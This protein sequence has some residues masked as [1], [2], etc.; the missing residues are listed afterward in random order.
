MKV[1]KLVDN[2]WCVG[3][4]RA[5]KAGATLADAILAKVHGERGITLI[6]FGLAARVVYTCLMS[7][8]ERR[9]FTLVDS[10]VL[11]G[12]PVSSEGNVWV[13]MKSVTAGRLVN[14]YS[15]NDSLLGFMYRTGSHQFGVAGLQPVEGAKGIENVDVSDL[16]TD[17]SRYQHLMG[18][19]LKRI[20]WDD[21]SSA[22]LA[23][24]EHSL[25]ILDGR[26]MVN[27]GVKKENIPTQRGPRQRIDQGKSDARGLRGKM[28]KLT[29]Q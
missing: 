29:L 2:P 9:A 7:L 13:S 18:I 24:E 21:L 6:G 8:A 22:Q 26:P 25:A 17:H 15:E 12:G 4:V 5:D 16:V 20:G 10:A 1:S 11:I 28:G 14:I 23:N 19:I 27:G 3:I